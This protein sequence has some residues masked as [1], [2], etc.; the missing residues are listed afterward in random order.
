MEEIWEID[1]CVTSS[2]QGKTYWVS[3]RGNLLGV[4]VGDDHCMVLVE[5]QESSHEHSIQPKA[6]NPQEVVASCY[7]R[8]LPYSF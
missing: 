4:G 7:L 6:L 1:F 3:G 5:K 2:V 8:H